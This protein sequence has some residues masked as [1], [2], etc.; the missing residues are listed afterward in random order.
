MNILHSPGPVELTPD[1]KNAISQAYSPEEAQVLTLAGQQGL[2]LP[3]IGEEMQGY[4]VDLLWTDYKL[5]WL[6]DEKNAMDF[7]AVA[8]PDWTVTG[9]DTDTIRKI[10]TTHGDTTQRKTEMP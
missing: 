10:L 4:V 2:P 5:A 6:A 1:W 9:P 8:P 3:E 7:A